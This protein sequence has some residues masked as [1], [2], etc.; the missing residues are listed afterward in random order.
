MKEN[1]IYCDHCGKELNEMKYYV[2]IQIELGHLWR[3][4]DLCDE[5]LDDLKKVVD[6]FCTNF[7]TEKEGA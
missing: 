2:D 5:C 7:A 6:R 4:H 3:T 1:K